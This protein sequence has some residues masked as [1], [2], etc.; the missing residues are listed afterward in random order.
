MEPFFFRRALSVRR[1]RRRGKLFLIHQDRVSDILHRSILQGAIVTITYPLIATS[2]S[3][4]RMGNQ[5]GARS[6]FIIKELS[7]VFELTG[8]IEFG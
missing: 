6:G 4:G 7:R 2:G 1:G 3:I 5:G 8:R